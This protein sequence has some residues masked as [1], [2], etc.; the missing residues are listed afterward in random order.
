MFAFTQTANCGNM[1]ATK[2]YGGHIFCLTVGMAAGYRRDIMERWE[3][4]YANGRNG[5]RRSNEPSRL[6]R[7]LFIALILLAVAA[8]GVGIV[9]GQAIADRS[10]AKEVMLTRAMTECGDAVS[11]VNNLSRSGGSDTAGALGKIRANIK[12]VDTMSSLRQ[13]LYGSALAPQDTF[14]GIYGIIDS[15][16]AK[17][18]NGTATIDELTRLGDALNAL[19]QLLQEA[20]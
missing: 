20:K 10:R 4:R 16:S 5:G 14:N 19:L 11:Q 17:L 1:V 13:S 9:G 18:K 8:L 12:A 3:N 7:I 15:Y 2:K 6:E